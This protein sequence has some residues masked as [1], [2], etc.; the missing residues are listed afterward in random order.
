M[1]VK[2]WMVPTVKRRHFPMRCSVNLTKTIHTRTARM[3][4]TPFIDL[5][6]VAQSPMK[7]PTHILPGANDDIPSPPNAFAA[8]PQL[9]C[10]RGRG[11]M[12]GGGGGEGGK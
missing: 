9:G 2:A 8:A 11:G 4:D 6:T 1:C 5:S 10:M 7:D 3:K 12:R